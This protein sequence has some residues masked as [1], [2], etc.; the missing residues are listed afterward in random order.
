[1]AIH[2]KW[3]N[4]NAPGN[5]L[6]VYRKIGNLITPE[7]KGTPIATLNS[8]ATEYSDN[9]TEPGETYAYLVEVLAPL[10][11]AYSRPTVTAN[12]RRVG[13]G[14]TEILVGT[15]EFGYMGQVQ[16]Y[17]MPDYWDSVDS[18]RT[19]TAR[20]LSN[21]QWHKFIRKGKILI[22]PCGQPM[23]DWSRDTD[24]C[25]N[26]IWVYN[27]YGLCSGL[28]WNFDTSAPKYAAWKKTRIV[29]FGNDKFHI[30]APRAYPDNWDGVTNLALTLRPDTEINQLIQAMYL[31]SIIGN[32]VGNVARYI[33][34]QFFL[35]F[36][37]AESVINYQTPSQNEFLVKAT[38]VLGSNDM[39]VEGWNAPVVINNSHTPNNEQYVAR[40]RSQSHPTFFPVFELI[41]E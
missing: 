21:L 10:G 28:E 3:S 39:S 7:T 38:P 8:D 41:E 4:Q 37:G 35:P 27:T 22:V 25:L 15:S 24:L 33:T 31:G 6:L 19:K 29:Q 20:G 26:S 17:E 30:R 5:Q 9:T 34:G 23:G 36:V 14:K 12:L 2:L 18:S 40:W 32:D 1:M 13:P 11:S 16:Q